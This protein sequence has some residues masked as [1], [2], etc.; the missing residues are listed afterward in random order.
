MKQTSLCVKKW[1]LILVLLVIILILVRWPKTN[2]TNKQKNLKPQTVSCSGLLSYFCPLNHNTVLKSSI[3]AP[4]PWFYK[5]KLGYYSVCLWWDL[6]RSETG[7]QVNPRLWWAPG[8]FFKFFF[9]FYFW[10]NQRRKCCSIFVSYY[11]MVSYLV[12]QKVWE[13]T[14]FQDG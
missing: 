7:T 10:L 8:V 4:R 12:S 2:Q 6:I 9:F 14:K 13:D 5:I 3:L 1:L 11:I